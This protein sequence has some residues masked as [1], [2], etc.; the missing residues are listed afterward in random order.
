MPTPAQVRGRRAYS[1]TVARRLH[2]HL[3]LD[4]SGTNH[5]YNLG[6]KVQAWEPAKFRM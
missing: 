5:F 2:S 4:F 6:R 3:C 1:H